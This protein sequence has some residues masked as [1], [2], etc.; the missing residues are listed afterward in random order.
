[1]KAAFSP[2]AK[3]YKSEIVAEENLAGNMQEPLQRMEVCDRRSNAS[4][5][6]SLLGHLDSSS[7]VEVQN[8]GTTADQLV[9]SGGSALSNA[10]SQPGPLTPD[11]VHSH[12]QTAICHDLSRSFLPSEG[13]PV[14][15]FSPL[16][17]ESLKL[18]LLLSHKHA[19]QIS[20]LS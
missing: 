15:R 5:S 16:R 1:M 3:P 20:N 4:I 6:P 8:H 7:A 9:S 12:A 17:G 10:E 2:P 18:S 13:F 14:R 19:S 11:Q